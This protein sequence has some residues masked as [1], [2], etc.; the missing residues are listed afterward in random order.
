MA[1]EEAAGGGLETDTEAV[2]VRSKPPPAAGARGGAEPEE[3]VVLLKEEV[4]VELLPAAGAR[5][6]VD[7]V[8]EE[9]EKEEP[10]VDE[11]AV[12]RDGPRSSNM[13][14]NSAILDALE[15]AVAVEVAVVVAAGRAGEGS[16]ATLGLGG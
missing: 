12:G 11:G 7:V 2:R 4:V 8:V 15:G 1:S 14:S 16:T 6:G 3:L 10:P 13:D 5:E 9:A